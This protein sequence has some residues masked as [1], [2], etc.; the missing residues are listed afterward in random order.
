M[1]T[2]RAPVKLLLT[3]EIAEAANLGA[4]LRRDLRVYRRT[5]RPRALEPEQSI[6][7]DWP[8]A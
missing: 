1:S 4:G 2:P 7:S 8:D 5:C 6:W 3:V